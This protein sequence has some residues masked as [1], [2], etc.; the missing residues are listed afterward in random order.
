MSTNE[1]PYEVKV[2]AERLPGPQMTAILIT[3]VAIIIASA[4]LV[5]EWLPARLDVES[6]VHGAPDR[7]GN[8][9]QTLLLAVHSARQQE[10][11]KKRSLEQYQWVDRQRGTVSI[12]I[13]QAMKLVAEQNR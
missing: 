1:H 6:A 4:I 13:E 2:E 7:I 8:I 10:E 9:E 3:G 12:P 11:L 5:K